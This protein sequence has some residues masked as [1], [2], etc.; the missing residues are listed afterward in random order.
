[1]E[2]VY[3]LKVSHYP[4]LYWNSANE[5]AAKEYSGHL[6]NRALQLCVGQQLQLQILGGD[7]AKL[8]ALDKL[9]LM[10]SAHQAAFKG[11]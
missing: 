2:K 1:M 3:L 9:H 4:D 10:V 11:T 5:L 7:P 6:F 8:H